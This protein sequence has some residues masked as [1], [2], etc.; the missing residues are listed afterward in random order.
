MSVVLGIDLGTSSVKALLIDCERGVIGQASQDYDV[1][2]PINGY[3]EQEPEMWWNATCKILLELKEKYSDVFQKI[4]AVGLSGQMHGLVAVDRAG[5][6][7]RPAIIWLD[8]RSEEQVRELQRRVSHNEIQNILQNEPFT[9]F[10]FPS[11]LWVREHEPEIYRQI[12]KIF[13]PKDYIRMK[14]TGKIASDVTDAA[15]T[16]CFD[17]GRRDWAYRIAEKFSVESGLLPECHESTEVAGETTAECMRQ[18]GLAVGIPVIYGAGDQQCQGIGN[19]ADKEGIVIS[20]IGTGGEISSYIDKD[21]FDPMMRTHTFC[22]AVNRGYIIYG[23]TLCS[24]M[25]LKWLKNNIL[26]A[27]SFEELSKMA[28]EIPAGSDGVI[29]LPHLTG[30]R[31]PYM[32]PKA[33]GILFGLHLKHD[34]RYLARAVMEGVVYSLKSTLEIFRGLGIQTNKIIASGGAVSSPVWLQ[35]QAD[36]YEKPVVVSKIKEQ[37]ALGAG[38]LAALGAG[39]FRSDADYA[40]LIE[41]DK[42]V[43]FPNS[44]NAECYRKAYAVFIELYQRNKDLF[45]KN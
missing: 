29:F 40:H 30:E 12:D 6:P 39:I 36:I 5:N 41:M 17:I 38:I 42:K 22:H 35:I 16:G 44:K 32:N 23:A 21:V 31:T 19:G 1:S 25:S 18:T 11:L 20:N 2:I 45:E 7:V 43:Y 15:S 37:A 10:A 3:A 14:L 27:A 9:G 8:Q 4:A 34:S 28:S 33:K 26:K 24:G 13:L